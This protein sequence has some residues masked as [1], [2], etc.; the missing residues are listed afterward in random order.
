M[1]RWFA[2]ELRI[3]RGALGRCWCK[4]AICPGQL[5]S[6]SSI[7]CWVSLSQLAAAATGRPIRSQARGVLTAAALRAALEAR[8]A[9]VAPRVEE[10]VAGAH[11][12]EAAAALQLVAAEERAQAPVA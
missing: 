10:Q 12:R 9:K 6:S 7:R 2:R 1:D 4:V 3:F 8:R 11:A 5:D